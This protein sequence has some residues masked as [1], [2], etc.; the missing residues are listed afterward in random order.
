MLHTL[1]DVCVCACVRACVLHTVCIRYVILV[2]AHNTGVGVQHLYTGTVPLALC[3]YTVLA[4]C[5]CEQ[6]T[7]TLWCSVRVVIWLLPFF[8]AGRLL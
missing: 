1:S 5:A 8:T 7:L 2:F 4:V 3:M 6:V